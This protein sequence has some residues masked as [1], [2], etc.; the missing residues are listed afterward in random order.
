MFHVEHDGSEAKA[1]NC[2]TW[3]IEGEFPKWAQS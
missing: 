2:S 3:N 1:G